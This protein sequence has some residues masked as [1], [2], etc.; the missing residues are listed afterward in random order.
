M[1]DFL[2]LNQE[3]GWKIHSQYFSDSLREALD[4]TQVFP[5]H[6][7]TIISLQDHKCCKNL[8]GG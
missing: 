3:I 8:T 5:S 1:Y 2:K 6:D 4:A 7:S